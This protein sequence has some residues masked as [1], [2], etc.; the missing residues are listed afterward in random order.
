MTYVCLQF[1]SDADAATIPANHIEE[2]SRK[3][4]SDASFL[5]LILEKTN[6]QDMMLRLDYNYY[7]SDLASQLDQ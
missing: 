7:F 3:F 5:F 2:L 6:A 1:Y 4:D